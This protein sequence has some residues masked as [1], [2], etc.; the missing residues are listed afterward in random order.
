M[1]YAVLF[2]GQGSQFVGMGADLF[3][4]R[5]D[6][7]GDRVD[8][9]LGWSLRDLCLAGP[10]ELLVRTE[11][12][13]PAL[14]C[15]SF[16]LWAELSDR[17]PRLPIA[18]A[19]HSL[20][21]YTALAAAGVFG[22]EE[23]L[24]VVSARGRAMAEAADAEDS[25]MVA[26]MGVDDD[27]AEEVAEARRMEGGRLVVANLNAPGQVVMAGG[28]SDLDWLE[29]RGR[30]L[31][32]RR[33]VRLPVAGAFH[34]GFMAPAARRVEEALVGLRSHP[35]C[36]PVYAN[37]SGEPMEGARVAETLVTQVSSPVRFAESLTA[38]ARQGVEVFVH[39]GP[40]KVTAGL[41]R[42]TVPSAT[43]LTVNDVAGA[44]KV[45]ESIS[46]MEFSRGE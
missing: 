17:L 37:V 44:A 41:A 7:L 1:N 31:G 26:L 2:P 15:L 34:S 22:Y 4:A 9:L 14:F 12:A 39:V 27:V 46:S 36:F 29:S 21:E 3:E 40:G 10:E 38:M 30:S 6:L 24:S 32:I 33:M 16:A 19:G 11:R 8:E 45:A 28:A 35:A 5:P 20:G 13:Q 23:T 42:R 25:G 18:A 43:V